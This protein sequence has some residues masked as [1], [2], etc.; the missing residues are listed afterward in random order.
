MRLLVV[1]L[2]LASLFACDG[3]RLPAP[4]PV[5][6]WRVAWYPNDAGKDEGSRPGVSWRMRIDHQGPARNLEI[7]CQT[8]RG[9]EVETTEMLLS[10]PLL[11]TAKVDKGDYVTFKNVDPEDSAHDQLRVTLIDL[12]RHLDGPTNAYLQV[13]R[14][15]RRYEGHA[16]NADAVV[17]IPALSAPGG[18]GSGPSWRLGD[19]SIRNVDEEETLTTFGRWNGDESDDSRVE[20]R[21]LLRLR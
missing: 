15:G 5:G 1:T 7:V 11:E 4:P 20:S 9:G 17:R 6:K 12:D 3:S 14:W 8:S 18:H 19:G 21:L 16:M 10:M 13:Q 2:L